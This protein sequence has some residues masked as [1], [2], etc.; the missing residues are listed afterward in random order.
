MVSV[1]IPVYNTEKYLKKT[2]DSIV[3]QN[4]TDW[5][6]LLIDDGST[7]NSSLICEELASGNEKIYVYHQKNKG[8]ASARNIGVHL[9]KGKYIVFIDSDD[10]I[11]ENFLKV[12]VWEIEEKKADIVFCGLRNIRGSNIIENLYEDASYNID[13]Y[14]IATYDSSKFKTRSSCNALYKKDI[15]VKNK[16]L[17]PENLLCGEDSIFVLNYIPFCNNRIITTSRCYYDYINQNPDSTTKSIFFNHYILEY[18]LYSGSYKNSTDTENFIRETGHRYIDIMIRE[19]MRFVSYS[20]ETFARKVK[21]I[22]TIV[23][24]P[25]TQQAVGYYKAKS[26]KHSK[27]I[28]WFI[29][30]KLSFLAFLAI[31]YRITMTGYKKRGNRVKSVWKDE[32]S[33]DSIKTI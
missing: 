6:I 17:F 11:P 9:S 2:V 32:N 21:Q 24:D 14:Y 18:K 8:T 23:N 26:P 27:W 29:K 4:Y 1:I 7:D 10:E 20:E 16:V 33:Y 19:L 31:K 15:I 13:E 12:M 5:E 30:K 25:L 28:P 22:H 3:N